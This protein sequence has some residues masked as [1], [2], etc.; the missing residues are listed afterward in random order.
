VIAADVALPVTL[1]G[2]AAYLRSRA[3]RIPLR[4]ASCGAVVA[5]DVLEHVDDR[6]ALAECRR[7]LR[8]G[9]V[10]V[11]SVPGWPSLWGERDVRAGHLRRYRRRAL[12]AVVESSRFRV[13]AV[14][15]FPA[16][17]LPL[18]IVSRLAVHVA[19]PRQLARE[20]H[21]SEWLNQTLTRVARFEVGLGRFSWWKPPT[22]SSLVVVAVRD[23]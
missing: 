21:V 2:G 9:G 1:E 16:L 19:G 22:G 5:R 14:R 15:G 6:A 17:L 8:P 12:L 11:A 7:V 13:L 23:D 3:E 20:E 18:V 4:D 10:L